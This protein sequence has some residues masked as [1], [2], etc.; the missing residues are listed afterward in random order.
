MKKPKHYTCVYCKKEYT[1]LNG[2]VKH[3]RKKH[4]RGIYEVSEIKENI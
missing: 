3:M 2:V 4:P 1:T